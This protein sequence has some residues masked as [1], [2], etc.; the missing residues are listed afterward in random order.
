MSNSAKIHFTPYPSIVKVAGVGDGEAIING[1]GIN[2]ASC[3]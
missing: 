1:I 2:A 3:G